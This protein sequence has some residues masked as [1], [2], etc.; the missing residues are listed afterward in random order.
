MKNKNK[1][2]NSL[3]TKHRVYVDNTTSS[4]LCYLSRVRD[5]GIA[6]SL[7]TSVDSV[8]G[9]AKEKNSQLPSLQYPTSPVG[10]GSAQSLSLLN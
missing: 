5:I 6:R 8:I 3:V 4:S 1:M 2:L 9:I 10:H 7:D